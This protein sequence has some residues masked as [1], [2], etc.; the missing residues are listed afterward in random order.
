VLP[1]RANRLH[2]PILLLVAAQ[3][4]S[5]IVSQARTL[6]A[7]GVSNVT[8]VMYLLE[9]DGSTV[10]FVTGRIVVV[11]YCTGVTSIQLRFTHACQ[12][13]SANTQSTGIPADK[14][15]KSEFRAVGR[16]LAVSIHSPRRG[17]DVL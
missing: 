1:N 8:F 13:A 17:T 4:V 5:R 10:V 7:V 16:G 2:T 15:H 11:L 12:K 3:F 6:L 9:L 14:T